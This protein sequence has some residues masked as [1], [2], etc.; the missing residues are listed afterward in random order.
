MLGGSREAEQGQ[1]LDFHCR[2]FSLK[3]KKKRPEQL[4]LYLAD[5]YALSCRAVL[6]GRTGVPEAGRLYEIEDWEKLTAD[7]TLEEAVLTLF[8]LSAEKG[9]PQEEQ[10]T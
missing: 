6:K 10:G 5:D 1:I 8:G 2:Y 4:R 3:S 9:E 7:R